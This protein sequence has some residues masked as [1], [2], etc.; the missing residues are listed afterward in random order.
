MSAPLWTAATAGE[1]GVEWLEREIA[2]VA[3]FGR[4]RRERERPF[5]RGQ[6]T[7]ARE[8]IALVATIA[9]ALSPETV[10]AIRAAVAA[11]PDPAAACARALSGAVLAD[12]ELF[13]VS[14][15]LDAVDDVRARLDETIFPPAAIPPEQAELTA[16]LGAGRTVQRTFYL[17]DAF[18]EGLGRSRAA[19]Q[20]AQVRYDAER[21]RLVARIALYAGVDHV[22]DGEFVLMRDRTPGPLP[23]EI[24]VL[25]EAPT[26]YLCE[27]AL[28]DVALE[29]LA[30]LATAQRSV[31]DDEE[32]VRAALSRNIAS[33]SEE[34]AAA[35]EA[36]GRIDALLGRVA[37]TQRYDACPPVVVDGAELSFVEARFLPLR[38]SLAE[39]AHRYV[40][41]TVELK[42]L[43]VLTGP[44]MGG[45]SA[46]LK[47]CG[48]VAACVALGV[49]VP[50]DAARVS[51]FDEIVHVGVAEERDRGSLLSS[52][53]QEVVH[54]RDFLERGA[55]RALVLIDEV[56]RTTSPHEGRALLIAL[57]ATLRER[58]ATG[59]A[60][61][62]LSGIA[63]AAG[64]AHFA[65]AGLRD[66][67][68]VAAS[69]N[70]EEA[71]ERIAAVMDFRIAQVAE[72]AAT[73]TDALALAEALGLDPVIVA[74]AR[75]AL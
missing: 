26:Y 35:S 5:R 57:I 50:A 33:T 41:L 74:R 8:A 20:V 61:T 13:D 38:A 31:A 37:F 64:V 2:P 22:R 55:V 49:P 28:D 29:A 3:D 73:S 58:G 53:G 52:F 62:H 32:R 30:A 25:R 51:L 34:F 45:K 4:R 39:H 59:L 44:N 42:G 69:P 67:P 27:V 47:T 19:A 18:D 66:V 75:A 48:F 43:G 1:I 12:V 24:R 16:L 17:F 60:A 71:I 10:A 7:A 65:V 9:Q 21:S 56:G 72:D 6:E 11:A 70:L 40:P 46:A 68:S 14:R 36:L 54:L 15:F 63:A 23:R